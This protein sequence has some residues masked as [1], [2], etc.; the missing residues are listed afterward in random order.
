MKPE[1]NANL[2]RGHEVLWAYLM[3]SMNILVMYSHL[4]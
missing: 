4:S 1:T 3:N 2:S